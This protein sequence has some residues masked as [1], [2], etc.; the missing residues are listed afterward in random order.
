[1]PYPGD[2]VGLLLDTHASELCFVKNGR[3]LEPR[4]PLSLGGGM[5]FAVGRYYLPVLLSSL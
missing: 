3:L 2:R 5:Y 4:Y 1:L